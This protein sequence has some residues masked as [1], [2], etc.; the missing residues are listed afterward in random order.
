MACLAVLV[1][2][3]RRACWLTLSWLSLIIFFPFN[4]VDIAGGA[5]GAIGSGGSV[6][7]FVLIGAKGVGLLWI[8]LVFDEGPT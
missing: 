2:A 4:A 5:S 8:H 3:G 1:V 6:A 7:F